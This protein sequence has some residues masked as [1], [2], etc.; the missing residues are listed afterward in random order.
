MDAKQST[1]LTQILVPLDPDDPCKQWQAMAEIA[2]AADRGR[3]W[4]C[5]RIGSESAHGRNTIKYRAISPEV[6]ASDCWIDPQLGFVVSVHRD[7]GATIDL[8][9]VREGPPPAGLFEI[10]ADFRKFDPQPAD[11]PHQA[12]RRVGR[13]AKVRKHL[14][15][16]WPAAGLRAGSGRR[17]WR[18]RIPVFAGETTA[19]ASCAKAKLLDRDEVRMTCYDKWPFPGRVIAAALCGSDGDQSRCID[20]HCTKSHAAQQ[21]VF[22]QMRFVGFRPLV[23]AACLIPHPLIVPETRERYRPRMTAP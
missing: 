21:F 14:R 7:D 8:E 20:G 6:A 15:S 10:P 22:L 11:R 13:A 17:P 9:N 3:Q 23:S 16:G 18:N 5:N 19:L 12:K 4:R 2:G 1:W